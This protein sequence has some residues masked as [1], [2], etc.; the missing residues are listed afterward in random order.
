MSAFTEKEIAYLTSQRLGRLATVNTQGELHVVPV[1]FI[2][3]TE[4]DTIDIGGVRGTFGASRKFR[5]A[6]QTERGALVVDD[7]VPG[8]QI[9]GI[10]VR[11]RAEAFPEGGDQ[12]QPGG[13]PAFIRLWPTRIVSWGIESEDYQP[14]SRRVK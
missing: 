10:E 5:D 11:G 13:D 2:Y 6:T 7:V 12:M 3:N 1:G 8:R 4:L 9:R 14:L